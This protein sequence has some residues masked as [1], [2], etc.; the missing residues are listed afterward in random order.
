M[1]RRANFWGAVP[2]EL[3]SLIVPVRGDLPPI[4]IRPEVGALV[5]VTMPVAKVSLL[6]AA[7]G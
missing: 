3:A 6:L 1:P 7:K 2:P 5:P 4:E